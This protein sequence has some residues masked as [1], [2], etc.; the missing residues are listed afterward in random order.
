LEGLL[1][2]CKLLP[3]L[4]GIFL[5]SLLLAGDLAA[6]PCLVVYPEGPCVYHYDTEEY[7]TV[8]PGH[9]LYDPQYD[10]GGL[11]LLEVG[12]DEIDE[13]IYQAPGLTGFEP[14]T[15]G[16]D[17]YFFTGTDC[18]VI[19]D[20]FSNTPT[21]FVNIL[22]VFDDFVP[23]DCTP[24]IW[25]GGEY[26]LNYVYP[27][28]DLVVSTPTPSG[29]NYSDT[30]ELD[31]SWRGCYGVHIWA[32]SDENYNGE[33]DGNECFTAFSHDVTIPTKESTWSNIKEKTE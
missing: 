26:L 13:S 17:G 16:N 9:P 5:L 18:T 23:E 32:F 6:D 10:R 28:G 3:F 4:S 12:T 15:E 1:K 29:N 25:V 11:V 27:I 30:I 33:R 2:E 24:D 31:I 20:G 8:G 22:L 14:S 19:I 21:T 7:Y